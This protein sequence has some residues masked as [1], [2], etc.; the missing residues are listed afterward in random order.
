MENIE[1]NINQEE[2]IK[3]RIEENKPLVDLSRPNNK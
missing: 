1:K 2:T 3:K